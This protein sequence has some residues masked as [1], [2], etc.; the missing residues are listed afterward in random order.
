M[1]P[2]APVEEYAHAISQGY[3]GTALDYQAESAA[4]GATET[5]RAKGD[6]KEQQDYIAQ[7]RQAQARLGTLNTISNIISSDKNLSLGYGGPTSL[8]IKMAL[9]QAGFDFGD[10]SGAQ[11]IQKLN[12]IL[13]SESAKAFSSRPTQ[14]EFKTFLANNPGLELDEK[15]N[16]RMLGILSQTAKR[17]ADL[18]KLARQNRDNWDNWDN[19]VEKYDRDN[20]IKD[21]TSGKVLSSHSII[22]PGPAKGAAPPVPNA[23]QAPDGN[24]YVPDP[25]RPG[26]Y[27]K[28]IQ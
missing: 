3:E 12:G 5:E 27:L 16:I 14:F 9:E 19:V 4:R 24:F 22:A 20:P 10:L 18:G 25:K 13:A 23:R 17:E 1:Q 7:G 26:K 11:S 8:K 15:G 21:P 2:T 28:V 6:V